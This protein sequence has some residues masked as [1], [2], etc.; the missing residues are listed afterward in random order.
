MSESSTDIKTYEVVLKLLNNEVIL[1]WQRANTSLLAHSILILA[2][3]T[4]YK[5]NS[6][7][8]LMPLLSAILTFGIILSF[9]WA[10]AALSGNTYHEEW[11]AWLSYLEENL[12]QKAS[13]D[14]DK[15]LSIWDKHYKLLN[16]ENIPIGCKNVKL[17]FA[18][19]GVKDYFIGLPILFIAIYLSLF[20]YLLWPICVWPLK[21]YVDIG[22]P[23][24]VFLIGFI[25]WSIWVYIKNH[26]EQHCS[27]PNKPDTDD[28]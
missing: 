7:K 26:K 18:A 2:W 1:N 21:I 22:L 13:V 19:I 12:Q 24:I 6:S 20:A 4:L 16:K 27:Q 9:L 17:P 25:I 14:S 15:L 11:M 10:R 5:V 3:S 23:I 8:E 28:G